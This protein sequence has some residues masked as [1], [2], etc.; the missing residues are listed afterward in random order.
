MIAMK[1][2][3]LIEEKDGDQES[4]LV[5]SSCTSRKDPRASEDRLFPAEEIYLGEQHR[6]LMRGIHA[7]RRSPL[8]GNLD[9]RIVSAGLG[10]IP[11]ERR[12]AP[13]DATFQAMP[14]DEID[15]RAEAMRIPQEVGALLQQERAM[16]IILLGS[17]YMRAAGFLQ[18]QTFSALTLIFC[19]KEWVSHFRGNPSIITIPSGH[20]QGR[21]L[22]CGLVWIKGEMASRLLSMIADEPGLIPEMKARNVDPLEL[23]YGA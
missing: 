2:E 14:K 12:I 18:H 8:T 11:G 6:R 16:N 13:Y 4:I 22:R 15:R 19:S 9:L 20:Q 3:A 21:D 7:F 1:E 10:L 23:I 17:E 5:L